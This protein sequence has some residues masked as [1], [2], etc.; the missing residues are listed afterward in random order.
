MATRTH[1]LFK[2][3]DALLQGPCHSSR[4]LRN[5][6]YLVRIDGDTL[7]IRFHGTYVVKVTRRGD[8]ILSAGG[9]YTVTTKD[10]IS[11]FLSEYSALIG[12]GRGYRL[13]SERGQWNLYQYDADLP[14][15]TRKVRV[16]RVRYEGCYA[17][18]PVTGTVYREEHG[19]PHWSE[20][21]HELSVHFPGYEW[22]RAA[23]ARM[24]A[25]G[26]FS[27]ARG[28]RADRYVKYYR[29]AGHRF[30][31]TET[32]TDESPGGYRSYPFYN[33]VTIGP[34]GAVSREAE[35]RARK[36]ASRTIGQMYDRARGP[37]FKVL[38]PD[39]TAPFVPS[40]QWRIGKWQRVKGPLSACENGLH[41]AT[42]KQLA[43]WIDG[44]W[45]NGVRSAAPVLTSRVFVAQSRGPVYDAGDKCV[46]RS[47]RLTRELDAGEVFA[48]C[49]LPI[50]AD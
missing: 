41:C 39:L 33:G 34:R 5:N 45:P 1:R 35:T 44:N 30:L 23:D 38:R 11:S 2:T 32:V 29:P 27:Y 7:A 46:T 17:L 3:L 42:S 9:W 20:Y 28:P 25:D 47:L 16:Y 50:P 21:G 6:T 13:W 12:N 22:Q 8:V 4:K 10:R 31:R 40:Y 49:S 18:S 24:Y 37:Y 26:R 14:P 43:R 15:K 48:R 19:S 36:H